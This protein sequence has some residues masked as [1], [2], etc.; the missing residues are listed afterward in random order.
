MVG[1]NDTELLSN[2]LL[3]YLKCLQIM[4]RAEERIFLRRLV[5]IDAQK[6]KTNN[7]L[8]ITQLKE[9]LQQLM[10]SGES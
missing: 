8:T 5:D 2:A 1:L 10:S 4:P 3:N 6:T 9:K 7:T